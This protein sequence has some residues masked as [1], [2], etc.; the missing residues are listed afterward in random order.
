MAPFLVRPWPSWSLSSPRIGG[1]ALP[2]R[3]AAKPLMVDEWLMI[4]LE[5][6]ICG[7][8]AQYI[9]IY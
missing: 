4:A 3:V 1:R 8:T 5:V 9:N 2:G 7:A 6:G